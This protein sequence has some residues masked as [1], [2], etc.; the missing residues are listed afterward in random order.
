MPPHSGRCCSGCSASGRRSLDWIKVKAKEEE[1]FISLWPNRELEWLYAEGFVAL[2]GP[3]VGSRV[4]PLIVRAGDAD[5]IE[6]RLA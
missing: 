5:E 1:A 6:R 4:V 3:L 2:V